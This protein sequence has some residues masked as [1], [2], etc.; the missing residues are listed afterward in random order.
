MGAPVSWLFLEY[1]VGS[2]LVYRCTGWAA[3][4]CTCVQGGQ[5]LGVQ[6]Y[7]VGS[8]LVYRVGSILQ[9]SPRGCAGC[10]CHC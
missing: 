4:W 8:I 5:H 1:R 7:R 6:V 9:R 3:S 2:I 10:V